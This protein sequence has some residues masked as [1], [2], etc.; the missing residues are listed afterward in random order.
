MVV[1]EELVN[2][3]Y[4]EPL[5]TVVHEDFYILFDQERAVVALSPAH[6]SKGRPNFL[7]KNPLSSI[8]LKHFKG[9]KGLSSECMSQIFGKYAICNGSPTG[10]LLPRNIK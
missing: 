9:Q 5:S 8:S 2:Y 6:Q 7:T 4:D 10:V 3:A 1:A